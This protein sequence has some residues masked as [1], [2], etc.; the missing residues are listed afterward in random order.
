MKFVKKK[1]F[2][3]KNTSFDLKCLFL[4][5]ISILMNKYLIRS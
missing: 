5:E 1:C 2:F 3:S 4:S